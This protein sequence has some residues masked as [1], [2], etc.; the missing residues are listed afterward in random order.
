MKT[1]QGAW[2]AEV[3]SGA[4]GRFELPDLPAG[5]YEIVVD[6]GQR[7]PLR[8]PAGKP[9]ELTAEP[10]RSEITVTASR[11]SVEAEGEGEAAGGSRAREVAL[12]MPVATSG[13][14]LAGLP[15]A[16]IQ[17]TSPGQASPFLRG[18]TGYQV[19][20]LV[21]G[22]RFNNA[23]FRSGPNQYL[24]FIDAS[25]IQRT[26]VSLGPSS[27]QY[28]SD[29]LGGAIQV[30]TRES[31]GMGWH[32]EGN[33][34][35]AGADRSAVSDLHL[36][37]GSANWSL[38][39]GVAGRRHGDLRAGGVD[40]RNVLRRFLGL[41]A[42]RIAGIAGSR[43][44]DTGFSQT[45][46]HLRTAWRPSP[47]QSFS[48]WFQ[49]GR[50]FDSRN[51]KDL[52][53]GLGRIRSDLTPQGLDL[54]YLRWERLAPS[55]FDT[56]SATFSV[57]SQRD[58]SVRQGLL[59]TGAITTDRSRVDALGYSA[60]AA[61]VGGRWLRTVLGAELYDERIHSSRQDFDPVRA[62]AR[63][64]RPLYPDRSAYRTGSVFVGDRVELVPGRLRLGA[65]FRWTRVSYA[66]RADAFGTAASRQGFSDAT[67]HGSASLTLT[68][69][70]FVHA[71]SGRGFRAPN[72]NDLGAIGLN[73]LGYEIP[74]GESI[75]A[76]ALLGSSA[77][78]NAMSLGRRVE[79]LRAESM[80][81]HEAGL[82]FHSGRVTARA[83]WFIA[84][85][86]DPIVRRTLLFAAGSAPAS[87]AG[88]AVRPVAPAPAQ[89]AQGVVAVATAI[90]PR[91]VKA[92]VNDGES[93]YS[94]AEWQV[95]ARL[96][97][98]WSAEA[99]Y[100]FLAGR[101]LYPNRPIRRLSP[102]QGMVSLR[103]MRTRW[104]M[105]FSVL[106]AGPQ[107]RLSGGDRDDERI[108]ASRSR[109]DI[110][111]FFVS[112]RLAPFVS[113]GRFT[114]TGETLRQ[115]QDRLLPGLP[116]GTRAVL[117]G[118]TA[119][120]VDLRCTGGVR[121]SEAVTLRLG[122]ANLANRSYRV[123]GSGADAAGRNAFAGVGYVF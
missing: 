123:H 10:L 38:S 61:R 54:G 23:T 52:W 35:A 85:L 104:W 96:A 7:R 110:A 121:L 82:R 24:A 95:R 73:D 101:D 34:A 19:L 66:T 122:L 81:N 119:G 14:Q 37:F 108:G 94:G 39:G 58:G 56:L 55:G 30:L 74:A 11:G 109:A 106:A 3:H 27:V 25:Q 105:E 116:D 98:R 51:Y 5:E 45:A 90:D 20:N 112:S 59:S 15:G 80:L 99:N 118:S 97:D 18:L 57:N 6:R 103:H 111:A 53:G 76:G 48:G 4:D 47:L 65:G 87:L 114:P 26:E 117:Y 102:Q 1:A 72:A 75:A 88:L 36:G 22:V 63:G 91:A 93:R 41:D 32:G 64:S 28:G 68:R 43:L 92:F 16:S 84:S 8:M 9:L 62:T 83:Q 69:N 113:A 40:S 29:S 21:D 2:I 31:R 42:D 120:W 77:G 33:V 70:W 107:R 86:R 50:Q 13:Q 89:A 71:M 49:T 115:I 17:Q 79:R 100:T 78:E 44:A 60:Q 12:G 67:W 46:A